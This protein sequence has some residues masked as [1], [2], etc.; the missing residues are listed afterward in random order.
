MVETSLILHSK[1]FSIFRLE[2]LTVKALS[3]KNET[4]SRL[5]HRDLL[6]DPVENI[7]MGV[8]PRVYRFD[9]QFLKIFRL[10]INLNKIAL[11][12]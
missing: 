8:D 6:K 1:F 7:V 5:T 2:V 11:W 12:F 3:S 10:I 4:L 9:L